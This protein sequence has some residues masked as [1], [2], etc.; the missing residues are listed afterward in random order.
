MRTESID[1]VLGLL[2]CMRPLSQFGYF[3]W[4]KIHILQIK[5]PSLAPSSSRT[6]VQRSPSISRS[7]DGRYLIELRP[8]KIRSKILSTIRIEVLSAIATARQE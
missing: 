4:F 1:Y 2:D 7:T 6:W 5:H 8:W 3:R